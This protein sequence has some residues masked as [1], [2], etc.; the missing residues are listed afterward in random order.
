MLQW[1]DFL[2]KEMTSMLF[3]QK[4]NLRV[5]KSKMESKDRND[6]NIREKEE[7]RYELPNLVEGCNR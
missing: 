3:G 4:N 5:G 1:R 2:G 6:I 7:T